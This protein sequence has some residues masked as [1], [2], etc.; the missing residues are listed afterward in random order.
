[1]W[2]IAF[3]VRTE[4]CCSPALRLRVERL[5][6]QPISASRCGQISV[7]AQL[8]VAVQHLSGHQLRTGGGGD[9]RRSPAADGG[10]A[11]YRQ[12]TEWRT[13][14]PIGTVSTARLVSDGQLSR[15]P[16]AQFTC[17]RLVLRALVTNLQCWPG[18]HRGI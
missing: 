11:I 18:L 9:Q 3:S 5:V 8:C 14:L 12:N 7:A 4:W 1:M 13:P 16:Q 2:T 10:G 6:F 15:P 17:T